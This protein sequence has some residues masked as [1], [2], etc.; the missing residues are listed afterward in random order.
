MHQ[1]YVLLML[2]LSKTVFLAL[3]FVSVTRVYKIGDLQ[4]T[5]VK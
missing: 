3:Q 5:L 1:T 4:F 2:L